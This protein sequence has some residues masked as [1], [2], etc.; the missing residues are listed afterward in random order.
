M[1]MVAGANNIAS[2]TGSAVEKSSKTADF[3]FFLAWRTVILGLESK[4]RI[5]NQL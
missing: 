1:E 4:I 2:F 3:D 5:K